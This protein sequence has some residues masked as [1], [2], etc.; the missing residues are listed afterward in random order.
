MMTNEENNGGGM[1]NHKMVS[2]HSSMAD[3]RKAKLFIVEGADNG[4]QTLKKNPFTESMSKMANLRSEI[5]EKRRYQGM[6][7]QEED[8]D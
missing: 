8:L 7:I 1:T 6:R 4:G 3:I 2:Q 5:A